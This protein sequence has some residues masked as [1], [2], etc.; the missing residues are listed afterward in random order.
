[1]DMGDGEKDDGKDTTTHGL[2]SQLL[3][4]LLSCRHNSPLSALRVYAMQF[5][6]LTCS[7]T[8]CQSWV[9]VGMG[10]LLCHFREI[11][12]VSPIFSHSSFPKFL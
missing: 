2:Y 5:K 1:M 3:N 7:M 6:L 9:R 8:V 4:C 12:L 10:K 11:K